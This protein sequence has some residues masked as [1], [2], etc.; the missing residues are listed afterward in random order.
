MT[1]DVR[2]APPDPSGRLKEQPSVEIRT[3]AGRMLGV[4]KVC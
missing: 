1:L 2:Q 4:A 3:A